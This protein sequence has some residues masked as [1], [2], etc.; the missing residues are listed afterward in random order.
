[1]YSRGVG[2]EDRWQGGAVAAHSGQTAKADAGA[3]VMAAISASGD[4]CTLAARAGFEDVLA[5][6]DYWTGT[7]DAH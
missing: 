2:E 6:G 5:D 3:E 4:R 1:M 7:W